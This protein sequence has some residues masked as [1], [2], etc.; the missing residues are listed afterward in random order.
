MKM[1]F[2]SSLLKEEGIDE[3]KEKEEGKRQ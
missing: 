1:R 3:M 2:S